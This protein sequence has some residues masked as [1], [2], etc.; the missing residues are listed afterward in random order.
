MLGHLDKNDKR[1]EERRK[2]A[3]SST[4]EASKKKSQRGLTGVDGT[5]T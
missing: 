4:S 3:C 1:V 5:G 2:Y